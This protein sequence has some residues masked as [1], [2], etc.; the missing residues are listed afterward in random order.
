MRVVLQRVARADVR[1]DGA[2]VGAIER[3]F[4]ALVGVG[5]D[6]PAEHAAMLADKVAG[7]RVFADEAGK[8]NLALPDVGGAVLVVS[9]FTL[10]GNTRTGRR[11][12]FT[13]AE[14]P[15]RAAVLVEDFAATLEARGVRVARGVFGADMQVELCN[16]GPVTLV[17]D[18]T[19]LART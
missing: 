19:D 8:M 12:S 10:Y 1:V 5:R 15:E 4:L 13:E 16:D 18:A 3:G 6:D 9:Q 7:L 11:P 14:D 2:V 17:L